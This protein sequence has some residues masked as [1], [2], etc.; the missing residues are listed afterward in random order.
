MAAGRSPVKRI[1]PT[2]PP[3]LKLQVA[4]AVG[5]RRLPTEP[6]RFHAPPVRLPVIDTDASCLAVLTSVT[7]VIVAPAPVTF[8]TPFD[9]VDCTSDDAKVTVAVPPATD[10]CAVV[11]SGSCQVSV[12]AL[13]VPMVTVAGAAP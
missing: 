4:A 8:T 5:A 2:V 6:M 11:P 3:L 13:A 7:S 12:R 10:R 1:D 9:S